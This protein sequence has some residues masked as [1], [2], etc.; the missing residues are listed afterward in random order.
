MAIPFWSVEII[1]R[2]SLRRPG[3][4]GQ[5]SVRRGSFFVVVLVAKLLS[6]FVAVV[7]RFLHHQFLWWCILEACC[8]VSFDFGVTFKKAKL[9]ALSDGFIFTQQWWTNSAQ[10]VWGLVPPFWIVQFHV[11]SSLVWWLNQQQIM[12]SFFALNQEKNCSWRVTV[13]HVSIDI[14][15]SSLF[16]QKCVG[17]ED[18]FRFT[19]LSTTL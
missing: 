7:L 9:W 19:E 17:W 5:K 18:R 8:V 15:S 3:P 13:F 2:W 12:W 6:S 11:I 4:Y 10:T 14:E 1:V 16:S